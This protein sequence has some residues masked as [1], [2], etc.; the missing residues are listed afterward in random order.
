MIK[1]LRTRF[2]TWLYIR[3]VF[4]PEEFRKLERMGMP[5]GLV[6][7]VSSLNPEWEAIEM[8]IREKDHYTLQ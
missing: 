7:S 5:Q 6:F 2:I 4:L 3:Y 8:A 1:R